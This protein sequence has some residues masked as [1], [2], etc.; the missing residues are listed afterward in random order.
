M[1]KEPKMSD[2]NLQFASYREVYDYFMDNKFDYE[3][4]TI[5]I[6]E[7]E[8]HFIICHDT[9]LRLAKSQGYVKPTFDEYTD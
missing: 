4:N 8:D 9:D 7:D 1:A 5:L 2:F 6:S 3:K